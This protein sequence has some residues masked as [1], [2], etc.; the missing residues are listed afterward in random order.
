MKE[1]DLKYL[2]VELPEDIARWK[3][4]GDFDRALR[5]IE[6]R[7]S[8]E[9]SLALRKRL[10]LEREILKRMARRYIY[11][12]EEALEI[13]QGTVRDAT[14]EELERYQ[15]ENATDWIF[16][17][18]QP[19]FIDNFMNNLL[20]T[21][22][23]LHDRLIRPDSIRELV[24]NRQILRLAIQEAKAAGGLAYRTRVRASLKLKKEAE[25]VG[26]PIRVYL[27]L[28][29]EEEPVRNLRILS[30]SLPDAWIA[31]PNYPQRT[32][33][34]ETCLQ[35]DQEF[36][37]EYTFENHTLYREIPARPCAKSGDRERETSE[38]GA[39]GKAG[40]ET[41][42]MSGS[43]RE[44]GVETVKISGPQKETGTEAGNLSQYL[45]EQLPHIRFSPYLRS[46]TEQV[47]GEEK[48]PLEKARR[49]YEY[50]TTHIMYSYVR[51][52]FTITSLA[53][54]MATGLKGDCGIYALLFITM[55]R[56][57]GVPARWQSGLYAT[58]DQIGCHDWAQFYIEPYGW[59]YADGSFGGAA[60]RDGDEERWRFY[61]GNLDPFRIPCNSEFQYPFMPP[62]RFLRD[63]PYDNQVGEAEYEHR[64][65]LGGVDYETE[66]KLISI[67]PIPFVGK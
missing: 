46:L 13:L 60:W 38:V 7:L 35:P 52:Y 54:Y 42:R 56:I 50:I 51:S 65:L 21:R 33:C 6:K 16:V 25:K 28:P 17:N 29:R 45:C 19:R 18:G 63:D 44:T 41:I 37:V 67:E 34:M 4:Y 15:D 43:Q 40:A 53:E 11:S 24:N 64:G 58:P 22:P 8:H 1:E 30:C 14:M 5:L 27:P 61:F 32:V 12:P 36:F 57:A 20:K 49:I 2:A 59:L 9:L 26:T 31:L 3:W 48:E 10:E 62:K 55:C 47:V 39:Q 23:E 66:Q